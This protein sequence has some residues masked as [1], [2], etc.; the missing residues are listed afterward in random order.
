LVVDDEQDE[1]SVVP[2]TGNAKD[3]E[4]AQ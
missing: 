4:D 2:T 1:Q 3:K